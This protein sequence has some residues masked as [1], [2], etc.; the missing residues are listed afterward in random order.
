MQ[1]QY[2]NSVFYPTRFPLESVRKE[3]RA[4]VSGIRTWSLWLCDEIQSARGIGLEIKG[5]ITIFE[6]RST[7]RSIGKSC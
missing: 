2:G 4:E 3:G 6:V 5:L 1:K 7:S